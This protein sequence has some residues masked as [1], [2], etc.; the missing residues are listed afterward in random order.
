MPIKLTTPPPGFAQ[1]VAESI[2]IAMAART[3]EFTRGGAGA[4]VSTSAP[5]AVY[6]M[7]LADVAAGR[8]PAAVATPIGWRA[9][10]V[11]GGKPVAVVE[12]AQDPA[13]RLA[14]SGAVTEGPLVD[15]AAAAVD[16]AER[17]GP[18]AGGAFELR[19]LDVPGIYLQALWLRGPQD[20]FVPVMGPNVVAR[21][22]YGAVDFSAAVQPAT[23]DLIHRSGGH[24]AGLS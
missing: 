15:Q 16:A 18:I 3:L 1:A 23:S 8:D 22:I 21:R 19:V 24:G 7:A 6:T 10:I 2:G 11:A 12:I 9:F 4:A 5:H 20:L 13:G 14:K 17:A